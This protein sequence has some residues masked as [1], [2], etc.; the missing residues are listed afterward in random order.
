MNVL[1]NLPLDTFD[2]LDAYAERIISFGVQGA[3]SFDLAFDAAQQGID[4]LFAALPA[5]FAPDVILIWWP[6]QSPLPRGL[7]TSPVP[8]IGILS[9]YNLTLPWVLGL[10]PFFDTLLVDRPGVELFAAAGFPDVR[11]FCQFS[12]LWERDQLRQPLDARRTDVAFA[13]NVNPAVQTD[14]AAW[15]RRLHALRS[16]PV[17]PLRIAVNSAFMA[18]AIPTCSTNRR[19]G[20]IDPCAAR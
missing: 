16:H 14:R 1:T 12:F 7:E 9:D 4:E 11:G 8:V 3:Q 19:W 18:R 20:S 15:L 2:P 13:G 17:D 6:D 10:W 5:E